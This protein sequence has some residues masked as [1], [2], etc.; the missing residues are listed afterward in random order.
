MD[1]L[2]R[3][4]YMNDAKAAAGRVGCLDTE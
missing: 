4:N 2:T 1:D 3:T